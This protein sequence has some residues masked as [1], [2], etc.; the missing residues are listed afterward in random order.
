MSMAELHRCTRVTDKKRRCFLEVGEAW[1]MEVVWFGLKGWNCWFISER[2]LYIY[3][4]LYIHIFFFRI[5]YSWFMFYDPF[6][7]SCFFQDSLGHLSRFWKPNK[8][9]WLEMQVQYLWSV[10]SRPGF[11]WF[12]GMVLQVVQGNFWK[13]GKDWHEMKCNPWRIHGTNGIFTYKKA[14][15]IN[16]SCR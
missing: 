3:I 1:N 5:W 16:H 9:G 11:A 8:R 4:C 14:I 7:T 10:C 12:G 6:Y 2:Y 13:V 15:N